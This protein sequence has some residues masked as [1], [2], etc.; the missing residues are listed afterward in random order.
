MRAW[1]SA[2]AWILNLRSY[3]FGEPNEDNDNAEEAE[4]VQP[5]AEVANEAVEVDQ[6]N[7]AG[8]AAA[9]QALLQREG[10]VGFQPY[11]KP[12][13]FPLDL[14]IDCFDV[15]LMADGLI[16]IHVDPGLDRTA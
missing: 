6:A 11:T 5:A 2:A 16:T 4:N 10:P 9:H 15:S 8:L 3:L 12:K 14:R 7:L 13:M 1:C